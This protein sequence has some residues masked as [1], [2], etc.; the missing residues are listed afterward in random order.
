MMRN[1]GLKMAWG[2]LGTALQKQADLTK[3]D[4]IKEEIKKEQGQVTEQIKILDLPDDEVTDFEPDKLLEK[5]EA[6]NTL[7]SLKNN[8][9]DQLK[10]NTNDAETKALIVKEQEEITQIMDDVEK[11]ETKPPETKVPDS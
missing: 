7:N 1:R 5:T 4:Q 11:I 8:I 9:D 2:R 6:L 3:D 10:T